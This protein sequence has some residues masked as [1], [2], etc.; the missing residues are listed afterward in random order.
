MRNS[1]AHTRSMF[2]DPLAGG[3]SAG[4][5][6]RADHNID[7]VTSRHGDTLAKSVSHKVLSKFE[8]PPIHKSASGFG[9]V[10]YRCVKKGLEF[11]YPDY[12][13]PKDENMTYFKHVTNHSRGKPDPTKYYKPLSWEKPMMN[14]GKGDKR[15]T[16][17]DVEQARAKKIPAPTAYNPIIKR[18]VPLGNLSKTEGV[19]YLSDCQYVG[20]AFPGPGTYKADRKWTE[21][22]SRTS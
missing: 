21:K 16:F 13:V 17:T 19:D 3:L 7:G 12:S 5:P 2:Q 20:K 11:R 14:Y 18:K 8:G 6:L 9:I 10:G 4:G 15:K 22:K 1:L